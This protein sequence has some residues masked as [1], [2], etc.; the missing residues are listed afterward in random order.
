MP[1]RYQSPY[2]KG[3]DKLFHPDDRHRFG[4]S[5]P[6]FKKWAFPPVKKF[7]KRA[8]KKY[9]KEIANRAPKSTAE[10][11]HSFFNF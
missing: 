2:K 7:K 4:Q 11:F 1:V 6:I 3:I 9:E 10:S 8:I 5:L